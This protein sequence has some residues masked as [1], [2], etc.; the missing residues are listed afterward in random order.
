MKI[1]MKK[2]TRVIVGMTALALLVPPTMATAETITFKDYT[3]LSAPA[4]L[5]GVAKVPFSGQKI[6]F[7]IPA[8]LGTLN[9]TKDQ[10]LIGDQFTVSG[11]ALLPKTNYTLTWNTFDG[12]WRVDYDPT[13]VNYRGFGFKKYDVILNNVTTDDQGAFSLNVV[14]PEDFGG[15]HSI[16]LVKDG[17]AVAKTGYQI[18]RTLTISPS[19]GPVGT[20]I[21]VTYTGMG[22]SQYGMGAS[23]TYDNHFMGEMQ[24][25]WTRG[26]GRT[27]I[28][29]AGA[30]GK[31]YIHVQNGQKFSYLNVIQSPIPYTNGGFLT[32]NVTKAK[33]GQEVPASYTTYPADVTPQISGGTVLT[34]GTLEATS[35]AVASLSVKEG[36]IL[37]KTHLSVTGLPSDG[38][39]T[40]KYSTVVG[41][42]V[43]C[44]STCWQFNGIQLGAA[45]AAGGKLDADIT[46]PDDLGGWH[47]VQVYSAD[48]KVLA[49]TPFYVKQSIVE[50]RDAK[51]KLITAGVA[52]ADLSNTAEA[53]ARGQ[54]GTP[55]YKFKEGEEF[56]ISIKGVGWTQ[57]DNTLGVTYDNGY[58]GYGCGF[59]SHGYVVIHLKA[60][61][62]VGTHIIDLWPLLYTQSPSFTWTNYDMVP[63]LSGDR[64]FPGLALGYKIPSHHFAIQIVK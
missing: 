18:N 9:V 49:Q 58:I 42:R 47:V 61:G 62:G 57:M 26:V 29:A 38:A 44:T 8:S 33:K 59:N 11:Q 63:V 43:N 16:Y 54:Q 25:F 56:T 55:G 39:M 6:S 50:F 17:A 60:T 41:N 7:T 21:T 19:S 64:D 27:T 35:K 40:L 23:V 46:I 37:T 36:P 12:L 32:F 22:G 34:T 45:T 4:D 1:M 13:T 30:L 48:N 20:P 51:G 2:R 28:R 15:P 24:A 31:H 10:G 3:E 5:P 52:G 53:I 14:A